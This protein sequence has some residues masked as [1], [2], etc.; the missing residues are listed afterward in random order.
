MH[1]LTQNK[2]EEW[3][4][5]YFLQI[6]SVSGEVEDGGISCLRL[7]P[8][9]VVSSFEVCEISLAPHGCAVGRRR[10]CWPEGLTHRLSSALPAGWVRAAGRSA[11]PCLLGG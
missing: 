9:A 3:H 6:F 4:C 10:A 8:S 7:C 11:Q 5:F 1:F 2:T